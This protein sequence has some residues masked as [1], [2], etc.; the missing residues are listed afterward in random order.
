MTTALERREESL[1]WLDEVFA[2]EV[3]D[4]AATPDLKVADLPSGLPNL[5]G[6]EFQQRCWDHYLDDEDRIFFG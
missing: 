4:G 2:R 6:Q 3:G 1:R 5:L